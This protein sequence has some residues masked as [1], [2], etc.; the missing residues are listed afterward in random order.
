VPYR[1][2]TESCFESAIGEHGLA[3]RDYA[4]VLKETGP[5]LDELRAAHGSA[6]LPLLGLPAARDDLEALKPV[7]ERYRESFDHVVVLGTGGSSLGGR[8]LCALADPGFGP[9]HGAPK[10]WFM[11]NVDCHSFAALF[12]ALDLARTGFI[13]ISKSGTTAETSAQLL[14]CL[15]AL[16]RAEGGA[17]PAHHVTAITEPGDNPMRRLAERFAIQVLDHDPDLGGRFSALS[18]VGLLPAMIAGLDAV[19]VREGASAV[20]VGLAEQEAQDFAPAVGAAVAVGLQRH[21]AVTISVLM[22][23]VDRLAQ[24]GMWYRQLWAESLGKGGRGTTPVRAMG[25]VDQHSQLQLYLDGPRDK[26][27]TLIELEVAAAGRVVDKELA[28][29]PELAYLAGRTM[30]D[31]LD[32]EQRAT[33]ETLVRHGRP[34]RLF[35]LARLDEAALGALMMHFMIETI[36]AAHLLGV[37]PFDQPA[38]EEGKVLARRYLAE[39]PVPGL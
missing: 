39:M 25:T 2:L 9:R 8:T 18:L 7:A 30:G 11:D 13:V 15:E 34:V 16:Q 14:V 12:A 3:L 24:L 35:R 5:A 28:D 21:R 33:A 29:D 36:I 23:Y 32:A 27:F 6:R 31:L 20:L 10:L 38:V 22:P 17:A 19:A 26:M 4:D 1:H 37:N